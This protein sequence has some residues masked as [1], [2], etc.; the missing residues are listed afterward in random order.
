MPSDFDDDL[1]LRRRAGPLEA[2]FQEAVRRAAQ[3][4]L[5]TFFST[6]E[7]VRRA[8]SESV[9]PDWLDYLNRQ[10][11][12]LRGELLERMSREFGE[13]LR[14]VDMAQIMSKLLEEHDFEL[15]ISVS[16]NRRGKERTG[17]LSLLQRRK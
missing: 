6:E 8:F 2:F 3:L 15:K 4:G 14:Q 12:D 9:P 13:W 1:E 17:E 7:A 16:A 5:S 11:T 10:G